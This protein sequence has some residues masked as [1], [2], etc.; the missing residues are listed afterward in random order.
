M[1]ER[2]KKFRRGPWLWVVIG[3]VALPL[4]AVGVM[5]ALNG[6]DTGVTDSDRA[7]IAELGVDEDCENTDT[8]GG[9]ID[10][11]TAVQRR[12]FELFPDTTCKFE[13]GET[14]HRAADYA[15]RGYGCCY[16]RATLIEQALR[17]Y[18]F[19]ARRVGVY[20]RQSNPLNYLKPGIPS[21][22]LSEIKTDRG[23]LTVESLAPFLAV[24]SADEVFGIAELRDGLQTGQFDDETFGA[25]IPS[26]LFD[27]HFVYARGVYSRHGYFFEPHLPVPEID[28]GR[29]EVPG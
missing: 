1:I 28:W 18:G 15:E 29:F 7:V 17:Q 14:G 20:E 8:F 25:T 5:L 27:G 6:V 11:I 2:L 23:W 12:V 13:R 9:E 21:H 19:D 3:I 22:A 10:C 16:D 26:N 4:V 24:N